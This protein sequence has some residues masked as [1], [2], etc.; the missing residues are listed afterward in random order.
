[1]LSSKASCL[2]ALPSLVSPFA[3]FLT[4][5]LE[6]ARHRAWYHQQANGDTQLDLTRVESP[7]NWP[8]GPR[9][10]GAGNSAGGE[11]P[12]QAQKRCSLLTRQVMKV[13]ATRGR[14]NLDIKQLN[15]SSPA[16]MAHL[17]ADGH[18]SLLTVVIPTV[19]C[20]LASPTITGELQRR[21]T[22]AFPAHSAYPTSAPGLC[23]RCRMMS[24]GGAY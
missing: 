6:Q 8:A 17:N 3:V 4:T 15:P 2:S 1:M 5:R 12:V 23:G 19:E 22:W 16:Y 14:V 9:V 13:T 21:R 18:S 20:I 7:L 11:P 10:G 24:T